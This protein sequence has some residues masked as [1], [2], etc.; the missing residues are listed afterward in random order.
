MFLKYRRDRRVETS[1]CFALV[2]ADGKG[3]ISVDDIQHLARQAGE[4]IDVEEANAIMAHS[5][6]RGNI[7][8]PVFHALLSPPSP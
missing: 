6:S 7:A 2:D 8:E 1:K 4:T 5:S 3:F